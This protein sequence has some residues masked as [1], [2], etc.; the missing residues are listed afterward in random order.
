MTLGQFARGAIFLPLPRLKTFVNVLGH[1]K[2]GVLLAEEVLGW[3]SCKVLDCGCGMSI[4]LALAW[5]SFPSTE[6]LQSE[7]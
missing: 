3:G 1:L 6:S 2:G 5:S 4:G 7:W